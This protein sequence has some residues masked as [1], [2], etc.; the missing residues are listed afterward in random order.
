MSLP[1]G[2][3][4]GLFQRVAKGWGI[5]GIFAKGMHSRI[6]FKRDGI[7]WV[8]GKGVKFSGFWQRGK[9]LGVSGKRGAGNS[10]LFLKRRYSGQFCEMG[11]FSI[12]LQ[13]EGNP[14][15]FCNGDRF[16]MLL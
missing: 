2:E 3:C 5:L 9:I 16:S 11:K 12:V 4:R 15:Y 8:F 13:K 1:K 6:F 7:L 14:R 10:L